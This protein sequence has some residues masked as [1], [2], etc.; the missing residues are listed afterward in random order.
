MSLQISDF[1]QAVDYCSII[2]YFIYRLYSLPF[3]AEDYGWGQHKI[4][5]TKQNKQT[6][7][8]NK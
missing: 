4:I 2:P 7:K 3:K 5:R 6:D 8:N 1:L